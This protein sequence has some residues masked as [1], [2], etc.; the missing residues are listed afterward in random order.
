MMRGVTTCVHAG[1]NDPLREK[2]I[3]QERRSLLGEISL[4]ER[5]N[6]THCI[7]RG[8]S[9]RRMAVHPQLQQGRWKGRSQTQVGVWVVTAALGGAS[10]YV[11]FSG[12]GVAGSLDE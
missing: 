1:G 9:L 3:M 7:S 2:L 6:G 5:Q 12:K 4:S 8:A 10:D 11:H